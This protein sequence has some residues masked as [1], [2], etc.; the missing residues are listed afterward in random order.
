MILIHQNQL[1]QLIY[2][3]CL[4][5]SCINTLNLQDLTYD[6]QSIDPSLMENYSV[7]YGKQMHLT[8]R[9][10]QPDRVV[11]FHLVKPYQLREAE[12]RNWQLTGHLKHLI[13]LDEKDRVPYLRIENAS[14]F[15]QGNYSL[16]RLEYDSL[17][18]LVNSSRTYFHI[19]VED[20][21]QSNSI[22]N[23]GSQCE[24]GKCLFNRCMCKCNQRCATFMANKC[25][26][27]KN[28]NETCY[29]NLDCQDLSGNGAECYANR[30][31]CNRNNVPIKLE[32]GIRRCV[33]SAQLHQI[34]TYSKQCS[35]MGDNRYCGTNYHC[36]C[37]PGYRLENERFCVDP[38]S[39]SSTLLPQNILLHLF[40]PLISILYLSNNAQLKPSVQSLR[41]HLHLLL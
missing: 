6:G 20:L 16:I 34:C 24:S 3:T 14:S 10:I 36:Q 29:V 13:I 37:L 31:R 39:G 23:D 9:R 32:D 25:Y 12:H 28:I 1:V 40:V 8:L 2:S 27:T 4:L 22:C 7:S 30:C 33:S 21:L 35:L 38:K 17:G 5:I 18:Y 41:G 19:D 26:P 11:R 15:H